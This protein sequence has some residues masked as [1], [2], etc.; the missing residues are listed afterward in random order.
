MALAAPAATLPEPLQAELPEVQTLCP[1]SARML[2]T[3]SRLPEK[4]EV[5]FVPETLRKPAKVEVAVELPTA[6]TPTGL[7]VP[8]P[9]LV[10][11]ASSDRTGL[12]PLG[13]VK[14]KALTRLGMVEVAEVW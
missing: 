6:N 12:A 11:K 3:T 14:A 4:V 8:I 2:P 9:T 10:F 5:E 13:A 1:A 7:A